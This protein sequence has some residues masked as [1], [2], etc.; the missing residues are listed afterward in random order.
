MEYNLT[1]EKKSSNLFD[2]KK[3][4]S[5]I[6]S[7]IRVILK[8]SSTNPPK[9]FFKCFRCYFT[10]FT[11][12]FWKLERVTVPLFIVNMLGVFLS[13]IS[14]ILLCNYLAPWQ[15]TSGAPPCWKIPTT[16]KH[17]NLH[18]SSLEWLTFFFTLTRYKA[19][20][21]GTLWNSN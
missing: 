7:T 14:F 4:I 18:R 15:S 9:T 21:N 1:E 2:L 20:N 6:Y 11:F 19:I 17:T 16:L 5:F 3:K 10:S 8:L 12:S 13:S